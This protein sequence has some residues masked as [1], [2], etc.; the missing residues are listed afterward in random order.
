MDGLLVFHLPQSEIDFL[1]QQ[2]DCRT[3]MIEIPA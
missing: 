1:E 2:S 3:Q